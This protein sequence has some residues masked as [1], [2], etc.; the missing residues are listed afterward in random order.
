M[1]GG[2]T[3]WHGR[4]EGGPAAELMAYTESLSFDRR[5]WPD[6]IEGSRAHVRMLAHVGLLTEVE[7]DSVLSA[8]E[9]VAAEMAAGSFLF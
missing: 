8:L 1:S 6:D 9:T 5:L 3:L 7:R 2:N 4:F